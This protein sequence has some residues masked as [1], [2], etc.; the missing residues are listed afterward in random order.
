M[1]LRDRSGVAQVV[2]RESEVAEAAHD[3]R[4]E[5]VLKVTGEVQRRREDRHVPAEAVPEQH[6]RGV[7]PKLAQRITHELKD[8]AGALPGGGMAGGAIAATPA[9]GASAGP[10]LRRQPWWI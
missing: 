4:S 5:Y 10:E 2:F 8:K 7:G 1:D 9:G 3:L 6:D